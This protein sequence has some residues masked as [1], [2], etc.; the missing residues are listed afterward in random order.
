MARVFKLGDG[1]STDAI[2]PG[3]Y[4]VTT[5]R[6]TLRR[7]CLV[8]ARP[9]FGQNVQPGDVI[10]AGRNFGCGSSREHAPLAIKEN[11]VAAV[12]AASFARIFYRNAVNIGLPV[13]R[14]DA[15]HDFVEDGDDAEVDV[16][17]ARVTVRGREFQ[18]EAPSGVAL[19]I[20]E[21]GSLIGMIREGGW[22]AVE[23][24]SHV[25]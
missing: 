2:I 8:E 23:E 18:G 15:L 13:I 21:A 6:D 22:A 7:G 16:A 10:V 3:R 9:D 19:R 5:D 17:R 14:C 11:G 1:V 24:V 20:I 25:S 12:V 4:N